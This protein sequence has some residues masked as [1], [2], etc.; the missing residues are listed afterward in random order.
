MPICWRQECVPDVGGIKFADD[1]QRNPTF[2][3]FLVLA[4]DSNKRIKY[5]DDSDKDKNFGFFWTLVVVYKWEIKCRF[6]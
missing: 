4:V 2:W 3:P 5:A 6:S 1:S